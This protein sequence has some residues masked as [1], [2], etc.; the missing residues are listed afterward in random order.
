MNYNL[1]KETHM[2]SLF[3]FLTMLLPSVAF[4]SE[5][6]ASEF[7][8]PL[9]FSIPK[10]ARIVHVP[11]LHYADGTK[12]IYPDEYSRFEQEMTIRSQL[13]IAK[14]IKENPDAIYISESTFGTFKKNQRDEIKIGY[15]D[16]RISVDQR[17]VE[18]SMDSNFYNKS[19]DELKETE[20]LL[21]YRVGAPTIMFFL[22]YIDNLYP[23]I[24]SGTEVT[25]FLGEWEKLHEDM[26]KAHD[27]ILENT[28]DRDR[29]Y[30]LAKEL[31]IFKVRKNELLYR[32]REQLLEKQ[33]RSLSSKYPK[34]KIFFV[35]GVGHDFA[36]LFRESSF[37]RLPHYKAIPQE[38]LSHPEWA[39][40]LFQ[41]TS[42]RVA[43]LSDYGAT[44][45][46]YKDRLD[47]MDN[48]QESYD[49]IVNH[50]QN[51]MNNPSESDKVLNPFSISKKRYYE[52]TELLDKAAK[53][54]Q[55]KNILKGK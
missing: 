35:Y 1:T 21:L 36:Y 49:I 16:Y 10:E 54:M 52:D 25:Y 27:I 34:K 6:E 30:A 5:Q 22:G 37:Y 43:L 11:Q 53:A 18:S 41:Y 20:K 50:V 12:D 26:E 48:Y 31:Q 55:F 39:L 47:M 8:G 24:G 28:S 44:E 40:S 42:D 29:L 17:M 2:K 4:S 38:Y 13:L 51:K 19:Y 3:I 9:P 14:V 33:V 7:V 15:L 45:I 46:S 32:G 23:S